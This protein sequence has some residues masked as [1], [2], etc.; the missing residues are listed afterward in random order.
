[1]C[2]VSNLNEEDMDK[3]EN[4]EFDDVDSEEDECNRI[5]DGDTLLLGT[6]RIQ[7]YIWIL[8][9]EKIW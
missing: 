4:Q 3:A 1:M 8:Y 2:F 5:E 7:L 6:F 9:K